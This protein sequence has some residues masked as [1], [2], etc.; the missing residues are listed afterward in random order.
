M[1]T[2]YEIIA[3]IIKVGMNLQLQEKN[4]LFC[5]FTKIKVTPDQVKTK[6]ATTQQAIKICKETLKT[7]HITHFQGLLIIVSVK[8]QYMRS[9]IKT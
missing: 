4:K 2:I 6:K 8:C 3:S 7:T 9:S 5:L 1:C